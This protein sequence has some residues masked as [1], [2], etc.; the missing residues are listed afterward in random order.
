MLTSALDGGEWS[1][2]RY[3]HFNPTEIIPGMHSIGRSVA[4]RA[5]LDTVE[6]REL[7]TGRPTRSYT[8]S[9]IEYLKR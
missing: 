8:D 9:P 4:P 2:S 5:G 3:D 6:Y 1:A 7:Y